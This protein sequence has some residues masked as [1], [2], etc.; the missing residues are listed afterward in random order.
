M[1]PEPQPS[2]EERGLSLLHLKDLDMLLETILRHARTITGADAGSIYLREGNAL[3]IAYSQN[4]TL[5]KNLPPG[6]KLIYEIFALPISAKSIAGYVALTREP[7]IIE[8]VYQLSPEAPYRF[9]ATMDK[10]A[11]YRTVSTL[12]IPLL[13][14]QRDLLGVLQ[15]INAKDTAGRIRTFTRVDLEAV[16]ELCLAASYSLQQARMMRQIILRMIRMAQMRDPHET[17]AHV[18]RVAAYAVELYEAWAISHSF[19]LQEVI[20]TRDILRMS[21]MLHDAGKVAV[22]DSILKKPGPLTSEERSVME[23]HT[24][25]GGELFIDRASE[26][27]QAAFEIALTH[28]ERWDGTGYPG[29]LDPATGELR[30]ETR[31]ALAGEEIPLL[32]RIVAIA[33]T[34][35]ALT[36]R[37][38][39]KEA[40]E[41]EKALEEIQRLAGT[42]F[43]PSLVET[44]LSIHPNIQQIRKRYPDPV[45]EA[46]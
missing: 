25:R 38:C 19:P 32:G 20:H 30:L 23:T 45:R 14:P 24:W 31:R 22:P 40:W 33:D 27:D 12:T 21:A 34:Y 17:G 44:F 11:G 28:H 46:S 8:D 9:E 10:V 3:K 7:L 37:R 4:E 13:T 16:S 18:N 6:R 26:F 41:E 42:A 1:N 15:L 39:Y 2:T 5:E 35:D 29:V 43:D 36:C